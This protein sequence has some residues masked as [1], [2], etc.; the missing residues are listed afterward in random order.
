MMCRAL[1]FFLFCHVAKLYFNTIKLNPVQ[2]VALNME[3][4]KHR[5]V[6][7]VIEL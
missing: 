5:S 2:P 4:Q 6:S 1:N 7:Y 3:Q